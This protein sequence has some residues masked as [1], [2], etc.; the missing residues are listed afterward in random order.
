MIESLPVLKK[1][2]G[3]C[4]ILLHIRNEGVVVIVVESVDDSGGVEFGKLAGRVFA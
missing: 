2:G 1:G 3:R 4:R